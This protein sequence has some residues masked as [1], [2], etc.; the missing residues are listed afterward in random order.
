MKKVL[1]KITALVLVSALLFTILS[2]SAGAVGSRRVYTTGLLLGFDDEYED[3]VVVDISS[4]TTLPTYVDNSAYFPPP[5]DQGDQNC[6]VGWA[7]AYA[8]SSNEIVKRGWSAEASSHHFSPSYIYNQINEGEN[9]TAS[10]IDALDIVVEQGICPMTYFPYND[11]DYITQPDG[12]QTTAASMYKAQSWE[13]IRG[14]NAI[15]QKISNKQPVI[16]G[17]YVYQELYTLSETNPI[18]DEIS[19]DILGG[20]TLCLIGYDDSIE[21]FK[22]INSWGTEWGVDGYGWISYDMVNSNSCN[23]IVAGRGYV[24]SSVTADDYIMGDVNDDGSVSAVDARKVLQYTAGLIGFEFSQFVL[25]DV[26]GDAQVTAV[27]AS[28]I[29]QYISGEITKFPLYN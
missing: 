15:K 13:R 27:D 17:V 18:Y 3:D 26:N 1:K 28:A 25:G 23:A 24:L 20:H 21:A 7:V 14:I 19:G 29:L 6:C 8:H 12:L 5:G 4:T 2:M 10:L 16:I 22:F 9:G 11:L